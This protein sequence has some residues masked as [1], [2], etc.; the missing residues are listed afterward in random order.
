MQGSDRPTARPP[1]TTLHA[2]MQEPLRGAVGLRVSPDRWAPELP[3]WSGSQAQP[4][5]RAQPGQQDLVRLLTRARLVHLEVPEG[6][7][8]AT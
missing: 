4:G 6:R 2:A 5:Q 3:G 7:A 8:A 1:A